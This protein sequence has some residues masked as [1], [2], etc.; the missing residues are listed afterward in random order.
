MKTP[1]YLLILLIVLIFSNTVAQPPMPGHRGNNPE[2]R[3]QIESMKI[4][5][6]TK[7]LD[8]SPEEAKRF[9]PVYNQYAEELEKLRRGRMEQRRD[10]RE[11]EQMSE[12]DY[13][14]IVD[15]EI[16]FR[17]HELDIL[18]KYNSQFK[19]ILPMK[20]VAQLYR[21]EEDFKRELLERIREKG[22][23]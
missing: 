11:K 17:Q 23:G 20:K 5:F 21:A 2:R 18:K 8:L 19:Q 10:L 12:A 7:R 4:A 1:K 3:E 15:G 9:W 16:S 22:R 6:L 13:E 14:K